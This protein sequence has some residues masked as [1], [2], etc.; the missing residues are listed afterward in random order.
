MVEGFLRYALEW[1]SET[2]LDVRREFDFRSYKLHGKYVTFQPSLLSLTRL[3][4]FDPLPPVSRVCPF[5]NQLAAS[6]T[7]SSTIAL[8]GFF[9]FTTAAALPIKNGR[10]LS[11]VSSSMSSPSFSKSSSTGIMPLL[12][13]SLISCERFSSQFL[14]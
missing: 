9:S 1:L 7:I 4:S 11:M 14:M 6:L 10:A 2:S 3:Y 5:L 12:V 8:A 13:R